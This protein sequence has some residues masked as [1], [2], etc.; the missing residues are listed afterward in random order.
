MSDKHNTVLRYVLDAALPE[1]Q[2]QPYVNK[3]WRYQPEILHRLFYIFN[4]MYKIHYNGDDG[5]VET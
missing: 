5:N 1:V 2:M 3:R 4:Y